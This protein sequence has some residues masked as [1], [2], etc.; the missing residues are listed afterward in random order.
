MVKSVFVK[1]KLLNCLENGTTYNFTN[2][3]LELAILRL[4]HLLVSGRKLSLQS[5]DLYD[6]HERSTTEN[7]FEAPLGMDIAYCPPL[8]NV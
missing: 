7:D 8:K 5:H 4:L 6:K 1:S 3:C 2:K